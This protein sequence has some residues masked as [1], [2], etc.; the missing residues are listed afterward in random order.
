MGS[1]EGVGKL[2]E[3]GGGRGGADRGEIDDGRRKKTISIPS[4]GGA[5]ARSGL[6]DDVEDDGEAGGHTILAW[7]RR[8]PRQ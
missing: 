8:W 2:G 7:G 5:L 1:Q 6:V 3:V 4:F